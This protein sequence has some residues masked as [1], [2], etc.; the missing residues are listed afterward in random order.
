MGTSC[1][2]RRNPEATRRLGARTPT[3]S[4]SNMNCTE[5]EREWQE[6]DDPALFSPPMEE[7]RRSCAACAGLV[8][9]VNLLRWEARQMAEQEQ[10][11][12]RLWANIR[13]EL[14]REGLV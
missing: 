4:E 12:A 8:R 13:S 10:P 7:H 1:T 11:P 6:L 14:G 2:C 3:G 9:E 5:F